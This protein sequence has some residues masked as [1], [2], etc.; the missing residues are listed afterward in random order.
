MYLQQIT[1]K[2]FRC[3][4]EITITLSSG[5]NI[6][7]GENNIGKTALLDAIRAALGPAASTGE[8]LKIGPDDRHRQADGTYLNEAIQISLVFANLSPDEQAQFIDILNYNAAEPVKSTAQ[9]NFRWNWNEK[10]KHYSINRWGGSAAFSENAVPEDVLQMLPVTLLGALRD[11]TAALQP[12]RNSRLAHL[13][14]ARAN[15][16][17]KAAIVKFGKTTNDELEKNELVSK[18]QALITKTLSQ[19][20]GKVFAQKTAIKTSPPEFE[21]I[22]QGLRLVVSRLLPGDVE[23]TDELR[24]NGLGFN[25]LFYIA[26]V[27]LELNAQTNALLPL[28]LVEEPE[29]HLHPQLQTLLADFLTDPKELHPVKVQS[30]ITS[31][32]PTI[33]AHVP[34]ERLRVLHMTKD[35]KLY[36]ASFDAC[37]LTM[38]QF[39]QVRRML[40]VTR[41]SLLFSRGVILVEGITEAL[42]VPVLARRAGTNLEENGI[43]VVPICGVDFGTLAALFGGKGLQIPLALVTDGDPGTEDDAEPAEPAG[44]APAAAAPELA[45]VPWHQQ[46]PRRDAAGNLIVCDRVVKLKATFAAKPLVGVF[47]SEV[48]LEYSLA[49]ADAQNPQVMCDTW[50][51]LFTG[52]PRTLNQARL[53]ACAGNHDLQALAIWRGICQAKTT[54]SKAEFAQSL[55]TKLD[56]KN[57]DGTYVVAAGAFVIPAYMTAAFTHVLTAPAA[58]GAH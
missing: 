2:N 27:I 19:A 50:T 42:L 48:T 24:A 11:A 1:V 30:L 35:R 18:T 36:C 40:D 10:T 33:A 52:Q 20:S 23:I 39:A 45:E 6:L 51:S 31:H 54:R 29:A 17:D 34:P 12:G 25:N 47:H 56:Q 28:L 44:D 49:K 13:L 46:E 8:P 53:D 5:L 21:K 9:L 26:T 41:A 16:A 57:L 37:G 38:P 3:L 15:D 32:S 7:V 22:I 14:E 4:K 58:E 55:A 43:S